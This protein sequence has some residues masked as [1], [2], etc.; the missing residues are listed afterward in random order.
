MIS[1]N[2]AEFLK[3]IFGKIAQNIWI[4]SF[5]E[6]PNANPDWRG[7]VYN[8]GD[9][10]ILPETHN[11]YFSVA[12]LSQPRRIKQNF[13]RMAVLVLDDADPSTLPCEPSYVIETSPGKHQVGFI[14]NDTPEAR[15]QEYCSNAL[16]SLIKCGMVTAD[17]SGNSIVRYVRLPIGSNTKPRDTGSFQHIIH[18]WKPSL[19]YGLPAILTAL[20]ISTE[21]R[22]TNE[23]DKFA[24]NNKLNIRQAF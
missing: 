9:S 10:S 24:N 1:T 2:N 22:E 7:N 11:N 15:D 20:G 5:A 21:A 13:M 14:L 18:V 3:A 19:Q 16:K 17:K 23:K 4:C 12:E 6:S 8:L